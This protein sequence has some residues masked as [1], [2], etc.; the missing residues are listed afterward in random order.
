MD[1]RVFKTI[2]QRLEARLR[3]SDDPLLARRRRLTVICGLLA[4]VPAIWW[5]ARGERTVYWA[6]PVS[7]AHSHFANDCSKCHEGN[8]RPLQRVYFGNDDV[9]SVSDRKCQQC[10]W[11]SALDHHM[12]SR[13]TGTDSCSACHREHRESPS[14]ASVPDERCQVCHQ[15]LTRVRHSVDFAPAIV[16]LASHPEFAGTPGSSDRGRE[17]RIHRRATWRDDEKQ[18]RDNVAI[19]FPHDRHVAPKQEPLPPNHPLAEQGKTYLE[20][21]ACQQ[22]HQP[23]ADGRTMQPIR[24]E[25]HCA[26]CHP[27]RF[28]TRQ[29]PVGEPLPHLPLEQVRGVLRSRLMAYLSSRTHDPDASDADGERDGDNAPVGDRLP[30]NSLRSSEVRQRWEKADDELRQADEGLF[31]N[32]KT[33]CLRCHELNIARND[34]EPPGIPNQ[35]MSHA[36]FSHRD[37]EGVAKCQECHTAAHV[38]GSAADILLPSVTSCR[39][40]HHGPRE[41][42]VA[43]FGLRSDCIQCHLFHHRPNAAE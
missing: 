20:P 15:D 31:L 19:K 2:A 11:Q 23:A 8:W 26:R 38:S 28:S 12:T 34:M 22:C 42:V 25:T 32:V 17:H 7:R 30:W 41:A 6:H 21:I 36:D 35:W 1:A 16:S 13:R 37:H 43:R 4:F 33:G 9:S 40:C 3:W 14:L 5:W 24:Y 39:K 18:W 27:L 29:M 10:H